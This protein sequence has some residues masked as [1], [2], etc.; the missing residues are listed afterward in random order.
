MNDFLNN[1]DVILDLDKVI[2]KE[3]L[4]IDKPMRDINFQIMNV[5]SA[6]IDK[7][8]GG[9]ADLATST[10][11][12]LKNGGD[13]SEKNYKGKRKWQIQFLLYIHIHIHIHLRVLI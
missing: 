1:E 8:I 2:D 4:F 11:T 7:F 5:I 9:S 6:F 10:K 12:Y 3:K 13:F